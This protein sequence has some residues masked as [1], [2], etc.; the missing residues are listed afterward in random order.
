MPGLGDWPQ[1]QPPRLGKGRRFIYQAAVALALFLLIL[2]LKE[3]GGSLGDRIQRDLRAV[4][5]TE[6]NYQPIFERVVRHGLEAVDVSMPFLGEQVKP[7]G[8]PA[9]NKEYHLPVSGRL[10]RQFGWTR[11][12]VD[13]LE[14]FHVGIDIEASSNTPVKAVASGKVAKIGTDPAIGGFIV[15]DHGGGNSTLYGQ[16]QEIEVVLGQQVEGGQI[17]GSTGTKG[18]I[19][20]SG[21]HFEYRENGRPVDPLQEVPVFKAGDDR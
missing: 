3:G 2:A 17:I 20:G 7:V 4:L 12:P 1:V 18:D 5:T 11:D 16:L 9:S 15:V 8:V 14:K 10:V 13:G 6:W 21:L 19:P